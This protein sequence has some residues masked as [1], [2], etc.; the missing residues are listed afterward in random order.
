MNVFPDQLNGGYPGT[1]F[2]NQCGAE[3]Y[4]NLDQSASPLLSNCP[5]IGPDIKTCQ[6]AGKKILLSL[7]GG[8]PTNQSIKDDAS[9]VKFANFLWDAFG[10]KRDSYKGPRPFGDAV[11]DGFDFDIETVLTAREDPADLSRGYGTLINTLRALYANE[12]SKIYYISGAPQCVVPDAHLA[13]AIESSWFDFVFVQFYNTPQCSARAFFNHTYGA[14]GGPPTD[15]SFDAWASFLASSSFHPDVKLYLG[16]PAAPTAAYDPVMYLNPSEAKT[17]IEHFQA[18]HPNAFGGVMLFEATRSETN[19]IDGKPYADVLKKLL[20]DSDFARKPG[21]QTTTVALK[22]ITPYGHPTTYLR[23]S[24]TASPYLSIHGERNAS[25]KPYVGLTGSSSATLSLYAS[26]IGP[27]PYFTSTAG[28]PHPSNTGFQ[29]YS[30]GTGS[31]PY[32][33]EAVLQP[34]SSGTGPRPYSAATGQA[35]YYSSGAVPYPSGKPVSYASSG[36]VPYASSRP[37]PYASGKPVSYAL[38]AT[39]PHAP[40]KYYPYPS[41]G[42]VPYASGKPVPYA[43]SGPV[44]YSSSGPVPYASGKSV[45]YASSGTGPYA[46]GKHFPYAS[47]SPV[48]YASGK[49]R[50]YEYSS[51]VTPKVYI[52]ATSSIPRGYGSATSS[53]PGIYESATSPAPKIYGSATSSPAELNLPTTSFVLAVYEFAT[54]S[55]YE[56]SKSAI[57]STLAYRNSTSYQYGS[58]GLPLIN[59]LATSSQSPT[60]QEVVTI[61]L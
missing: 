5:T 8:V 59:P 29:P 47:S 27:I 53:T 11:V 39:V 6:A 45:P 37:V 30:T 42:P 21:A 55:T 50:V 51:S 33:S 60:T 61:V 34:Y 58:T 13:P 24:S 28:I 12:S 44:P 2:G 38:S 32:S 26:E 49:P 20:L 22:S 46:S 25:T 57:S 15:I 3:T 52:S 10:P 36:P 7:G 9:A 56:T 48:P 17:I 16:L 35:P 43:S 23:S 4:K 54:S 19:S 1:N 18:R 31:F 14:Y 40:G 41:G